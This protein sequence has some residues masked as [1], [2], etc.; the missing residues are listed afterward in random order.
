VEFHRRNA[1]AWA[2]QSVGRDLSDQVDP[3]FVPGTA[4]AGLS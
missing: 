3:G 1:R 2:N 4:T